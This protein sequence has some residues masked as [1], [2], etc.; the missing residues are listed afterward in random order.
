MTTK[1]FILGARQWILAWIHT[2]FIIQSMTK[3]LIFDFFV[4][5]AFSVIR[6]M[7]VRTIQF[8]VFVR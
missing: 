7:F 1:I 8:H 3:F 5:I 6:Q 4:S 2:S